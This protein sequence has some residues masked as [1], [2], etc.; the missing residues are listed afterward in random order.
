M[1]AAP[2]GYR[3]PDGP[4]S[5][6]GMR[7]ANL[8]LVLAAVARLGAASRAQLSESTGLTR[9]AVGSLVGELIDAGLVRERGVSLQGRVGRPG[10]AL[11]VNDRGPCGLGLE[12]GV[13]HLGACVVDLRHAVRVRIRRPAPG[14]GREP[15][16]TLRLLAG[17]ARAALAEAASQGLKPAG[18]AVAV[19]GLV[20]KAGVVEHAPNL[21]WREVDVAAELRPLLSGRLRGLPFG[22]ENE[23]NLGALAELWH[24]AAGRDF[25]HVSAEAGIGGALVV[26]GM[27]LR[28]RRGFAGELGHMPVHPDGRACP[29]GS[30]GCLEQYAGE[31][32]VLRS[33]GLQDAPG[34]RVSLLAAEAAA[35]RADVLGALDDAGRAL[36]IALAGAVNLVDPEKVVL[37]GAY[38]ELAA[39]LTPGMQ[40]E[41]AA[42]VRIRPWDPAGLAVAA[43]RREGP[44]VGAATSVVQAVIG[45]PLSLRP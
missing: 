36:G 30:H 41:L 9:A 2:G 27:L 3:E 17:L 28:G 20:A 34:D 1:S 19:P 38:A 39:W 23:A 18:V 14:R 15:R 4:A 8:A 5:Q 11:T 24:G 33:C 42:R 22:I 35:G 44:V 31:E 13:E 21:G 16:E 40:A 7:R 45:D 32:A 6:Q 26:G 25:V 29:C 43:L 37:G 12:I 10:T